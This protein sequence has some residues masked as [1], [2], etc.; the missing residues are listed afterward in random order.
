MK[1]QTVSVNI[2]FSKTMADGAWKTVELGTE[3]SLTP[4]EDYHAVQLSLYH[5]LGETMKMAEPGT[6]TG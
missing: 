1:V 6:A 5:E 2:R 4:D 3:A